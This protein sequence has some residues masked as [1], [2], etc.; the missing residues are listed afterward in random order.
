MVMIVFVLRT[1]RILALTPSRMVR[2]Q[3]GEAFSNRQIASGHRFAYA[4]MHAYDSDVR[5]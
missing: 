4:L 2:D 5:R 1:R 3:L